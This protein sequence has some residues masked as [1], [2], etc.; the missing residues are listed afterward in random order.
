MVRYEIEQLF[1]NGEITVDEIPALWNK[2]YKE[3]FGLDVPDDGAG[4]LQDLHW[5]GMF[6]YFP[7]YALGNAYG[8]QILAAMKK[9]VDFEGCLSK[10]DLLTILSW[11]KEKVFAR[12]SLLTPEQ[13]IR[14]ITGE[15]LN[16]NYYLDYLEE[17]FTAL[18][19]LK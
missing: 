16:V 13:W 1:I 7:S 4:C 15:E 10:G 14:E 17:K 11:L 3:Y 2:K 6:G 12:A 19:G 8:A 18:Y 5:T 9:E